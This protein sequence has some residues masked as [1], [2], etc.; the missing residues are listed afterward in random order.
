MP[1]NR[2]KFLCFVHIERAGGTTLRELLLHAFPSYLPLKPWYCWA[3]E[4]ENVF[5]PDELRALLRWFPFLRGVGGHTTRPWLDYAGATGRELLTFTFVREPIARYMSH[6]N[7][8]RLRAGVPWTLDAFL[9]EH[10]FDDYHTRR[11]AG[12]ADLDA[13][14]RALETQIGFVG[15]TERFDESLLLFRQALGEPDL[16]VRYERRNTLDQGELIRFEDLTSDQQER[17]RAANRLDLALYEHVCS[18]VYPRQV[19]TYPGDVGAELAAF[20]HENQAYRYPRLMRRLAGPYLRLM[21]TVVEPVVHA[22]HG[23][24]RPVLW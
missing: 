7:Y 6:L 22:R 5:H 4:P 19:A 14:K 20:R 11:L 15:L 2:R 9:A 12:R 21:K 1:S 10:R 24:A 17:V 8:Q 18:E 13:A 16:D 3:N 23:R